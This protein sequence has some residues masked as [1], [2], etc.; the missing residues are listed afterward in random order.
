[1]SFFKNLTDLAGKASIPK[2]KEDRNVLEAEKGVLEEK[3]KKENDRVALVRTLVDQMKLA[4]EANTKT[5]AELQAVFKTQ[6]FTPA[7]AVEEIAANENAQQR[8]H[9]MLY[10]H[11]VQTNIMLTSSIAETDD[12]KAGEYEK[13]IRD[14]AVQ[15]AKFNEK[16]K[17]I[18]E[19]K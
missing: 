11:L 3:L 5:V 19:G 4:L 17:K 15:I 2:L 6:K 13:Q 12:S 1:M 10:N 14:L 9:N 7:T 8:N 16:L 18:R